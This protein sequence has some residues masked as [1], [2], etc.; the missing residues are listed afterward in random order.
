[1]DLHPVELETLTPEILRV[2]G[3]QNPLLTAGDRGRLCRAARAA[4]PLS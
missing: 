4:S 2:F 1:M 3:R